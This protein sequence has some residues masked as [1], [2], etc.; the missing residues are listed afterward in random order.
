MK[1]LE[2]PLIYRSSMDKCPSQGQMWVSDP[3]QVLCSCCRCYVSPA[4]N[5]IV[6]AKLEACITVLPPDCLGMAFEVLGNVYH[7]PVS[8]FPEGRS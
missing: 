2:D 7:F 8:P 5:Q 3:A 1:I 6:K 4:D